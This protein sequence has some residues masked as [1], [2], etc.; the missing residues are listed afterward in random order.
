MKRYFKMMILIVLTI[1]LVG[2]IGNENSDRARQAW[3]EKKDGNIVI[4]VAGRI[5][6]MKDVTKFLD[7]VYMA[8]DEI[9]ENGGIEG[10]RIQIIEADDKASIMEGTVIAQ[11]FIDNPKVVAVIGHTSTHVSIP[12]STIYEKAGVVML[13]PIVSNPKLTQRGYKYVFQNIPSD[14]EIGKE[15]AVFAKKQGHKRIAIYYA[16]T[17]YGKGLAN[18]FEDVAVENDITIIDR[19]S[20][21]T[22]AYEFERA[23]NKWKALDVDGV[24][25]ADSIRTG[26]EFILKLKETGIDVPI[27]GG[28]GLDTNFI[29]E[30]GQ[31]SEGAA[32]ATIFNHDDNNPRLQSFIDK[33]Q[34]KYKTQPDVWALQG[35]DSIK[36]LAYAIE[37]AGGS[38][39][40]QIAKSLHSIEEFEGVIDKISFD[41]NGRVKGKVVYKKIVVSGKFKYIE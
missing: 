14:Y 9:N 32:I 17:P 35:Y 22:D 4:G 1:S 31:A 15:M 41:E 34:A 18:A 38:V 13:S 8:V 23:I 30:L 37:K 25:V 5:K 27:L 6:F 39:P 20:S 11:K 19:T 33:F 26:K 7:G 24:F 2:C 40:S 12:T 36:L 16:D 3:A 29:E 21:Y 28:D 10:R